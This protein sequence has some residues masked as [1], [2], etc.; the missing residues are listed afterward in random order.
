MND[1]NYYIFIGLIIGFALACFM[2]WYLTK[3]KDA[4]DDW[5]CGYLSDKKA[6]V[7]HKFYSEFQTIIDKRGNDDQPCIPDYM[8]GCS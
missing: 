5:W 1:K 8:G 6:E 7:C 2:F 4:I 3:D